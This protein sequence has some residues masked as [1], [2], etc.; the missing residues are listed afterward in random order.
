[1]PEKQDL[2]RRL[3]EGDRQALS[4]LYDDYSGALYGVIVRICKDEVV[5]QDILQETFL[6]I[7]KNTNTYDVTKG[8]F[9]TWAYRIAR[10]TALNS[11]RN[12]ANLIQNEDLS[13]Y[14]NKQEELT[15]EID[16]HALNGSLK[17]LELHH[18]EALRL[19]YFEGLTHRE[20]HLEMNVPLGTFKSYVQQAL[21]KLKENYPSAYIGFL[22][23]IQSI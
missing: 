11:I 1:M 22:L 14:S 12:K 6:K 15:N 23:I 8:R 10:N 3:Q 21:K 16:T 9:Y 2:I 18:Q 7:W 13:V 20:A 19:V 4:K 5:A 17:N